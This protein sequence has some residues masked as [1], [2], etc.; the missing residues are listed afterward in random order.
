MINNAY[1]WLFINS[2]LVNALPISV[3]SFF[4]YI[5]FP[6]QYQRYHYLCNIPVI[7]KTQLLFL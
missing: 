3:K 6:N 1:N 7:Q 5:N 2:F 4:F